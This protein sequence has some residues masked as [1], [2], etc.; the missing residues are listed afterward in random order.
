M[1]VA[2]PLGGYEPWVGRSA[3]VALGALAILF[4]TLLF[5]LSRQLAD[6]HRGRWYAGNGRDVFHAG[7]AFSLAGALFLGGVPLPVAFA[8]AGS[9]SVV[10]LAVL[11]AIGKQKTRMAVMLAAIFLAVAPVLIVPREVVHATNAAARALFPIR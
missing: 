8:V 3:G 11:D 10:P 1:W 9:A 6:R 4:A 7:A 2:E 5:E